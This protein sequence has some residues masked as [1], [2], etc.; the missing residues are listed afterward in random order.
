MK[1]L[2]K[3]FTLSIGL[4]VFASAHTAK[5]SE[6]KDTFVAS[7]LKLS[8]ALASDKK[9]SDFDLMDFQVKAK[10][11]GLKADELNAVKKFTASK[12][13]KDQREAFKSVSQAAI[14]Y[15][16]KKK[17]PVFKANCPMADAD[18][19][20]AKKKVRNPYYGSSM[21]ACG[22]SEKL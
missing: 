2:I 8:E 3:L 12:T 20:Q 22:T 9:L 11:A 14:A 18:W 5:A 15:A 16:K 7:Y 17:L 13:I 19:L 4:T 21:L 6:V 1:K 10:D